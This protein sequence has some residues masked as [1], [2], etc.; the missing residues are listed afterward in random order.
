MKFTKRFT[1]EGK[2]PFESLQYEWRTSAIRHLDGD[3]VTEQMR[4]EVPAGWSQTAVDI[5]AQKYH[6]FAGRTSPLPA[7]PTPP[8]PGRGAPRKPVRIP[9]AKPR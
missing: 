7:P 4:V 1:E 6:T 8:D 2:G 5:L 3:S 9:D